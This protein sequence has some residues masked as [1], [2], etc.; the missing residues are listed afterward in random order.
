VKDLPEASTAD[1]PGRGGLEEPIP[2]SSRGRR[3]IRIKPDRAWATIDFAELWSYRGLLFFLVW[4]DVKVRYA[5]TVMGAG[6]AILQ[7]LI[8]VLIF[9]IV[10]GRFARIPSDGVPYAVFS[11][12]AM[13]P[14]AYFS[15]AL[16]ASSN[17]LVGATGMLTKIYFP[18]LL[19]PA[20]PVA[21]GL[22]DF[23]IAFVLLLVIAAA[24]GFVPPLARMP[25]LVPLMAITILT[26][27]G[28]GSFLAAL[29]V[30][31]RDVKQITPFLA[32]IW[33]FASPIVYPLSI[34]PEGFRGAYSLNP[35][36]GVVAGF[37]AVLLGNAPMPWPAILAGGAGSIL[38]FVGGILYFKHTE[39]VFADVA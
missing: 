32:Q 8:A 25:L 23:S 27:T 7:P 19:L 16:T 17:S 6:W 3:R 12:A 15:T 34:V 39:R 36:V 38:L 29:N 5:Q 26:A 9:T 28:V 18:R 2:A 35:M 1:P 11:M 4:R 20:A 13:V 31:Y 10:F 24:H 21:A 14:W 37:R 33:M 30:Q 22:V